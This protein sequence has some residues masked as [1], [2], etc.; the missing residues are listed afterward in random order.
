[1]A[2]KTGLFLSMAP[3]P[4]DFAGTPQ[5]L[6]EAFIARVKIEAPFGF[7]SF[8]ISSNKP[9]SNQGPWL[10]D[11]KQWWVWSD[12]DADY[13]PLDISASMAALYFIQDTEPSS[14]S[15]PLWFQTSGN[16]LVEV[17]VAVGGNWIPFGTKSGPTSSRP[18]SPYPFQKFYDTTISAW[19]WYERGAWRTVDGVKGD[20]KQVIFDTAEQALQTNPGWEILGTGTTNDINI[21]GRVLG[22]ATKNTGGAPTTDLDV[23]VG[24]TK[25]AAKDTFGSETHQLTV[26]EMPAHTHD[27]NGLLLNQPGGAV[28]SGGSYDAGN[29]TST[30]KGGNQAHNNLQPTLVLWTLVKT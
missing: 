7:T 25:R 9:T 20:V 4:P 28:G 30:S 29:K 12:D 21:R 11:G 27:V 3:L 16:Q 8:V 17:Y 5:E 23:G 1:M 10:K 6:L 22:Q 2:N 13:I 14:K 24:M 26:S 19:I 15:P 18:A